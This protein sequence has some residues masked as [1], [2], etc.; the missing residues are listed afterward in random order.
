MSRAPSVDLTDLLGRRCFLCALL[1]PFLVFAV[2]CEHLQQAPTPR[3]TQRLPDALAEPLQP[4]HGAFCLRLEPAA[5]GWNYSSYRFRASTYSESRGSFKTITGE[6]YRSRKIPDGERGP[7]IVVAPIL[8]GAQ[9]GYLA[10]RIFS[11]YACDSGMSAFFLYQDEGILSSRSDGLGLESLLR[12]FTR[13]NRKMLDVFARRAEVD[14][15]RLGS[16]GISLGAI[17]NLLLIAVEPRLQANV[18][19]LGGVDLPEIFRRSKE[20]GVVRYLERRYRQEGVT[21]EEVCEDL[22]RNLRSEPA[23]FLGAISTQRVFLILG[24]Y[25][26]KVPY[27]NGL[28]MKE[29]LGHPESCILPAGHYTAILLA[30]YAA[31]MGFDFL[32]RRFAALGE[33]QAD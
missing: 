23:H 33:S 11:R 16:L 10:S 7:L 3:P 31:W 4:R 25:D 21:K 5:C 22:S 28:L 27:A 14:P 26:D 1:L 32:E 12:E 29:G 20:Y 17:R 30:W 13:D 2:G 9:S 15:G 19:C 6:Y 8:G 24:R 18:L